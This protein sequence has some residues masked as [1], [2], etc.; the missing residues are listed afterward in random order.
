[1][2]RRRVERDRRVEA[3]VLQ[4]GIEEQAAQVLDLGAEP[5]S[6]LRRH[7]RVAAIEVVGEAVTMEARLGLVPALVRPS[8]PQ[9]GRKPVL[10]QHGRLSVGAQ[11][12]DVSL[13]LGETA[14]LAQV[15]QARR[16]GGPRPARPGA[17]T[18]AAIRS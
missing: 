2:A 5:V 18:R 12:R 7:A 3:P 10:D 1:M 17:G 15:A 11:A 9:Q 13:G 8:E 4:Q 16:G 6:V 14:A